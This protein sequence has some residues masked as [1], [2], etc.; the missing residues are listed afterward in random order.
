MSAGRRRLVL[1]ALILGEALLLFPGALVSGESFFE[2]DLL[3]DWYQRMSVLSRCVREGAWPVWDPSLAFG[4][5]LLADPGAQILYP[6]A[7]A[8]FALPVA[9]GYTAFVLAHLVLGGLGMAR[10][11]R[12]LGGSHRASM[13]AACAWAASGPVQSALNLRHHFAGAAWVPWVLLALDRLVRAPGP[14]SAALAGAALAAQALAG[15]PDVCMLTA[16]LA[17]PWVL[18]RTAARPRRLGRA[19]PWLAGA[20]LLAAGLSA[21]QWWPALDVLSRSSRT[22]LPADVRGFWSVPPVGLVRAVVP[23]DPR[24]VPFEPKTWIRLYDAPETPFLVSIY[25]GGVAVLLAG[26]ALV[27]GRHRR[28]AAGLAVIAVLVALGALG[29]HT[30]LYGWAIAVLPPLR[31]LRYPS[32]GFIVVAPIVALLAAL[33]VD[34]LTRSRARARLGWVAALATVGAL[35][36]A[37]AAVAAGAGGFAWLAGPVLAEAGAGIL[38]LTSRGRIAPAR[39]AGAISALCVLDLVAAHADLNA[40][41]RLAAVCAPP[42]AAAAAREG[43]EGRR[44]YVYD[45][46]SIRRVSE[47]RLARANAYWAAEPPPGVDRR[48]FAAFARTLYMPSGLAGL[49]G[50][51]GS[52]DMD[53][54]GLGS[55]QFNDLTYTLRNVEG[56]PAQIRMLRM[57]AVGT[58]ISLHR[59]GL[60]GLLFDRALPSLYPEPILVWRVPGARPRAWLVG[61]GVVADGGAALRFL[62]GPQFDPATQAI[63]P[64]PE[65]VPVDA[66]ECGPAGAARVVVHHVDRVRVEAEASRP[67]VLVLADAWDPGWQAT[68]DGRPSPLLRV[69]LAFRGAAVPAGRHVIEMTYR[70]RAVTVGLL[71]S[72]ASLA[73]AGGALA[74]GRRT[75]S[76]GPGPV[77]S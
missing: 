12:R 1:V 55:S 58:V 47:S 11:A 42:P 41:T 50:L 62:V 9:F 23:L 5:P 36:A 60:E 63:V 73:F 39:A 52:Y 38:W 26:V 72:L 59:Q 67:A 53:L 48:A 20:A 22:A 18:F 3:V 68:V 2:R 56:T 27:A 61:C 32:K 76:R 33:G 77:R 44:V 16:L 54:R 19:V 57:G 31:L 6:P 25:V 14:R 21:A 37:A 34:A 64:A 29:P 45:Y 71:A 4:Y 75:S 7:W 8:A 10:L 70:P 65:G 30:P 66:R 51:E 40:T 69:N 74:L 46:Y 17:G 15:S 43:D 49:F 24:R 13:L 35:L 28:R